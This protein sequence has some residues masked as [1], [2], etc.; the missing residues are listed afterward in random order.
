MCLQYKSFWKTLWGEREIAHNAKFFLFY[1]ASFT[2]FIK[3]KIVV[4][5]LFQFGGILSLLFEKGL[6][7]IEEV[8]KL[9]KNMVKIDILLFHNFE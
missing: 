7:L 8:D 5:K 2:H 3:I 4:C 1:T 6:H 9:T